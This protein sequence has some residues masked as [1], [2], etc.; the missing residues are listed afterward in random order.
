MNSQALTTLDSSG[1]DKLIPSEISPSKNSTKPLINSNKSQNTSIPKPPLNGSLPLDNQTN[2][3]LP[4]TKNTT[5]SIPP[6]PFSNQLNIIISGNNS[7][8]LENDS[9]NTSLPINSVNTQKNST[10]PNTYNSPNF[11]KSKNSTS[12][13]PQSSPYH[14]DNRSDIPN[15]TPTT[16][17]SS[18]PL[19]TSPPLKPSSPKFPLLHLFDRKTF[20]LRLAIT[21][22]YRY[23]HI[24]GIQY[25]ICELILTQAYQ[26]LIHYTD[27]NSLL[28][29]LI[30][31][32][33]MN[34]NSSTHVEQLLI[35]LSLRY[36]HVCLNIYFILLS[37]LSD[38]GSFPSSP[39]FKKTSHI[40]NLYNKLL[41]FNDE[42]SLI[43]L[44]EYK[45][46]LGKNQLTG[47]YLLHKSFLKRFSI[48]PKIT[49]KI[50]HNSI[51]ALVGMSSIAASVS[52]PLISSNMQVLALIEGSTQKFSNIKDD[53]K[54]PPI[55]QSKP[56]QKTS[57]NININ[58]S[59]SEYT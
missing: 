1:K 26:D 36:E 50:S 23:L 39:E 21:Y 19:K 13:S 27:F 53:P 35:G 18:A 34:P 38:L 25:H 37:Y 48:T 40:L 2:S 54:S 24:T 32:A 14:L 20:S 17:S 9:A 49:P 30:H 31:I 11:S 4:N 51:A 45:N 59:K 33:I 41:F 7:P 52:T 46:G 15:L 16:P 55:I 43:G 56:H 22:L 12:N 47:I 10:S 29:Q 42:I 3:I 5:S 6:P 8:V 44:P 57:T 58:Q 28:P